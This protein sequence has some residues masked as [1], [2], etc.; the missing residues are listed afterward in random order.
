MNDQPGIRPDP[1]PAEDGRP[2]LSFL[3]AILLMITTATISGLFCLSNSGI[4]SSMVAAALFATLLLL[5]R[6]P[7]VFLTIPLSYLVAFFL[8]S[9]PLAALTALGYV[10]PAIVLALAISARKKCAPTVLW[11]SLVGLL[12][13]GLFF[14]AYLY[15]TY[16]SLIGGF[17]EMYAQ[18]LETFHSAIVEQMLDPSLSDSLRAFYQEYLN[19]IET[20][21]ITVL[22]F[23]PGL[24]VFIL[25]LLSWITAKLT[26]RFLRIFRAE[27][28]YFRKYWRVYVPAWWAKLYIVLSLFG[29]PLVFFSG[30]VANIIY[31]VILNLLLILEPPILV[32]G[33]RR[34]FTLLRKLR[35]SGFLLLYF[36]AC[37]LCLLAL[38]CAPQF[39]FVGMTYV[40]AFHSI[41]RGKAKKFAAAVPPESSEDLTSESAEI[42][43]SDHENSGD[44]ADPDNADDSE[45]VSDES[46]SDKPNSADS[47]AHDN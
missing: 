34:L 31:Y 32:I 14:A 11:L 21:S 43:D 10:P 4:L 18:V 39:L 40:G 5:F 24:I 20:A 37:T 26:K 6:H 22:Y 29:M 13:G 23:L 3:P 41:N 44:S 45:A 25:F 2:R 12:T 17:S 36:A 1:S 27:R 47:D 19:A 35:Q 7:L 42:P 9:S 16:G 33:L 38:C 8:W 46:E 30:K 28:F 15:R